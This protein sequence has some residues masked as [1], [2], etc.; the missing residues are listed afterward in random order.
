MNNSNQ[1]WDAYFHSICTLAAS[2]SP[3]LS[4]K[5]GAVLVRDESIISTGFNGPPYKV[6]HC[7]KDRFEKDYYLQ[8]EI[9]LINMSL[10]NARLNGIDV[11]EFDITLFYNTCPRQVLKYP[12]GTH[13]ELCFAQHAEEN[14][15]SNAAR[16]GVSTINTT[17]YMNSIVPCKNCFG[18]LIN[19]GVSEIVVEEVKL[20]D[21][22]CRFLISHSD[23]KIREFNL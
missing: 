11:K 23:I 20:Y 14:T 2:K 13:M 3:C 16:I 5:I 22:H 6:P 9:A 7:G 8:K 10:E 21:K 1:I 12:S 15:I 17:L 19:A 18:T 4:R